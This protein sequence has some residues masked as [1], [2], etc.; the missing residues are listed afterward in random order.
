MTKENIDAELAW[1]DMRIAELEAENNR[2]QDIIKKAQ[3]Q[4]RQVQHAFATLKYVLSVS[5]PSLGKTASENVTDIIN[6]LASY[7]T[8]FPVAEKAAEKIMLMCKEIDASPVP[9]MP[10][11]DDKPSLAQQLEFVTA[12]RDGIR[13]HRDQLLEKLGKAP[14]WVAIENPEDMP[15]GAAY[16]LWDGCELSVDFIDTEVECG[17]TFFSNGTE[18]THY[19]AGLKTPQSEVKPS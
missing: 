7:P 2:L 13:K 3:E 19:L 18:A 12:E 9:A 6:S 10:I 8:G 14:H 15:D 1:R 17:T 5:A 4:E 11:Q 16:V